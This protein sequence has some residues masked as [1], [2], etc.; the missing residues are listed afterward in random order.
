LFSGGRFA[1]PSRA[2][3]AFAVAVDRRLRNTRKNESENDGG[4]VKKLTIWQKLRH[5]QIARDRLRRRREIAERK[6]RELYSLP[7]E[8]RVADPG[9][10]FHPISIYRRGKVRAG[11][12]RTGL[13]MP[14]NFCLIENYDAVS[15]F[16]G[17]LR[18]NLTVSGQKLENLRIEGGVRRRTRWNK[19]IV[20]TYIDFATLK[21]ITPVTALVLAS[22]YDQAISVFDASEWLRAINVDQW[23][24]EVFQTLSDVGFLSLLGV[25]KAADVAERDGVITVPFLSGAKV[26]GATIDR[27]I[28]GMATLADSSGVEDSDTLLQRSRVYDGLGEAIQNVEDHAYPIGAFG[29]YQGNGG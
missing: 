4:C 23:D 16:L 1:K 20:D 22:E 9:P 15:I 3:L 7:A 28:R 29:D 14:E 21:R 18:H 2:A 12:G 6:R 27:L 13:P 10:A 17:E 24:T 11:F 5:L 25:D 26:H 8:D 19:A